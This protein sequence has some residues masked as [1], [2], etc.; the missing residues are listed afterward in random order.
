MEMRGNP[1][2]PEEEQ[3]ADAMAVA[4]LN[5]AEASS[6]GALVG[7]LEARQKAPDEDAWEPWLHAHPVSAERIQA[8]AEP[9]PATEHP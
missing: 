9:C 1:Y 2:L 5:G 7:L 3:A 4:L 8:L 6:C